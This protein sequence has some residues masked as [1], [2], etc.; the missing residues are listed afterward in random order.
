MTM[1]RSY[2][3]ILDADFLPLSEVKAGLSQQIKSAR[4]RRRRIMVTVNGKPEA[5]LL[6]YDDYLDLIRKLEPEI[7]AEPAA[8]TYE[9]WKA[10]E[11]ARK[12]IS[13]SLNRMFDAPRLSRKGQKP[14]KLRRVSGP[15]S[16]KK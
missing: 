6:S 4:E 1:I 11:R 10:G 16:L 2:S 13:A 8:L 12:E 9:E 15:K 5:V 14:Y 7:P 3:N